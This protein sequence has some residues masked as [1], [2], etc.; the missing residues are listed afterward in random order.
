MRATPLSLLRR[1]TAAYCRANDRPVVRFDPRAVTSD[2]RTGRRIAAAYLAG[3]VADPAAV[4]SYRALR[5]E[6]AA[7]FE[8]L[9]RPR[10]RGG[11]GVDVR[12][13]PADPYPDAVAMMADLLDR[14]RLR[15]YSTAAG[16]N[17][18]P[19]L[20]ADDNDMFRAVHDAFGHAATG[21]GFDR[22]GEEAAWRKHAT[23]YSPLAR[24][25]MT[26]E[27]RGQT[28]TFIYHFQ[29]ARF[30]EQKMFLLPARFWR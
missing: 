15:V 16:G 28:C 18:H 4:P 30:P 29:G 2:A 17:P 7:Q 9:T 22:H 8:F 21:R 25:A 11:L 26:T 13:E 3:P 19:Y 5:A 23:M 24:P 27:T 1:G 10:A 20:S 6:T 14:G 12:V